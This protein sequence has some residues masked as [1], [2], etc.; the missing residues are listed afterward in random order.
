M[1]LFFNNYS[2]F[3]ALLFISGKKGFLKVVFFLILASILEIGGI[4]LIYPYFDSILDVS[5]IQ[6]NQ[7]LNFFFNL[8]GFS[9]ET[10]FL[11]FLG[12]LLVLFI[13]LSGIFGAISR[14]IIDKYI[15]NSNQI[16]I[17]LSYKMNITRN[18]LE[19]RKLN[20]NNLTN[21]IISE[22]SV[23]VNGLMVPIF[24]LIPRV[25]M[26]ILISSLILIVNVKITLIVFFSIGLIYITVFR[27]FREKLSTMSSKRFIMQRALLNYVNTSLKGIKDIKVNKFEK[28]YIDMVSVPAKEYSSLNSAISIFS[29]MPKYI[30][31]A[32]VFSSTI[33]IL[34]FNFNNEGNIIEILPTLSLFAVAAIKLLPHI[35]GIF[36]S[37]AKI[38]FNIKA[39]DIIYD[40]LTNENIQKDNSII[41]DK[42]KSLELKNIFFNF[43]DG[44][45]LFNDINF[46]L[47]N[48]DFII[49][50]GKS[51]SG[52]STLV[53]IILGLI[54]TN[55]GQ[56]ILNNKTH[57]GMLSER[58]KI[59]YVA[60]EIMLFEGSLISNIALVDK[61]PNLK[62]IEN[63]MKIACLE[64]VLESVGGNLNSIIYENGKNLSVGQR[65]RISI[66]RSLYNS[67]DLL[68]LDEGSSALDFE[69]EKRVFDNLIDLKIA[70]LLITHNKS[71]TKYATRSFELKKGK[72]Y[73]I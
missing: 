53:D 70:I 9:N 41:I 57:S 18:Y 54:N 49:L 30:L 65:Q 48:D 71:L 3:K 40:Q 4:G 58:V 44:D 38:K 19:L 2:K 1:N 20:S 61:N 73:E 5:V 64:D 11:F 47:K 7:Y 27:V 55:S 29:Q 34:L 31:E 17:T 36:T 37:I 52:K 59:G 33:L 42:F 56:Y 12:I 60:Q 10:N 15:W 63:I 72:L 24:D 50:T 6:K 66:A 8:L 46:K 26:L 16:L 62:L 21:D 68:I 23:F 25:L 22:V 67:P 43:E 45:S 51:G 39:L 13:I 28:F 32:A 14:I 69:T 35:N